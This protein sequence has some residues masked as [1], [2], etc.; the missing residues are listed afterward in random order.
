MTPAWLLCLGFTDIG[1]SWRKNLI[2]YSDTCVCFVFSLA[3]E[4]A[5]PY[6]PCFAFSLLFVQGVR[7]ENADM[8]CIAFS[9]GL[10]DRPF[11]AN[12]FMDLAHCYSSNNGIS[13]LSCLV[14]YIFG[15]T[16]LYVFTAAEQC[17]A[18]SPSNHSVH[19]ELNPA[20]AIETMTFSSSCIIFFCSRLSSPSFS[21]SCPI[22]G[23]D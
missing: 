20:R 8:D 6:W 22:P 12:A 16:L 18:D 17:P 1:V 14:A 2:V 15:D 10:E 9:A 19:G 3:G 5:R 13:L 7:A 11:L 23:S 21:L 4:P